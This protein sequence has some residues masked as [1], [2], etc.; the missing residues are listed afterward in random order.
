[1]KQ[2]FA[3]ALLSAIT[4]AIVITEKEDDE[5]NS[6]A[7]KFN[8]SYMNTEDYN[9]SKSNWKAQVESVAAL[10]ALKTKAKFAV[11]F[12]SDLDDD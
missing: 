3:L 11:N 4:V 1:M 6:F 2:I 12:T 9:K 8:K 5:F 10:N 7:A